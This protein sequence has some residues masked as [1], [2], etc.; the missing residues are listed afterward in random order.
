MLAQQILEA[1]FPTSIQEDIADEMGFD[2]RT[3]FRQR[4]PKFRQAVLRAYTLSMCGL[5]LQY[6]PRQRPYSP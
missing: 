5:R 3:S 4:D 1:H 2:I 6:A